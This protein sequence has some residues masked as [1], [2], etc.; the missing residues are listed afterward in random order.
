MKTTIRIPTTQFAYLQFE[1]EGTPEEAIEEHN[2]IIKLYNNENAGL[3]QKEWNKL[4]DKYI[5]TGVMESDE[6]ER[7]SEKQ[8]WMVHELDK[9]SSRVN[10][11][12]DT[13]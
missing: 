12:G 10:R 13:K 1:F 2:R 9:S 4:L 8:S 11:S 3:D 7:M 6:G 5:L